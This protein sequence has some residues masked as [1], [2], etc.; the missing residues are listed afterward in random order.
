MSR[1]TDFVTEKIKMCLTS[2]MRKQLSGNSLRT[3]KD[4]ERFQNKVAKCFDT[5][6]TLGERISKSDYSKIPKIELTSGSTIQIMKN[7]N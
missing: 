5:N 1:I 7:T 4:I 3:H 6:A 2:D